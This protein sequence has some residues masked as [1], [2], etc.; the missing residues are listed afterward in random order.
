MPPA[1]VH[2]NACAVSAPGTVWL[3]PTTCPE[4]LI[5]ADQLQYPPSVPRSTASQLAARAPADASAPT[6]SSATRATRTIPTA[7][8]FLRACRC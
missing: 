5:A 2:E 6:R 3:L 8:A 7:T 4:A 1:A